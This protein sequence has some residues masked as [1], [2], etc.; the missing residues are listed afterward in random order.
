MNIS[1][2]IKIKYLN[3]I[4]WVLGLEYE[5]LYLSL[6]GEHIKVKRLPKFQKEL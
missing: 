4:F 2:N 1:R 5:R 3:Y 6:A